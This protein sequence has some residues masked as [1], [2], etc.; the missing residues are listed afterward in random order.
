MT[1]IAVS[2]R[3]WSEDLY[4]DTSEADCEFVFYDNEFGNSTESISVH[5][6]IL[7]LRSEGFKLLFKNRPGQKVIRIT[8]FKK[9]IFELLIRYIFD[10]KLH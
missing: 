9:S 3:S 1:A 7:E 8:D 6:A 4:Y 2:N 10:F 5:R